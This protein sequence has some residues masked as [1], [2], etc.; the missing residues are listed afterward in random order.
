MH[1]WTVT[2][3]RRKYGSGKVVYW[4]NY[5]G[6]DDLRKREPTTA[7]TLKEAQ[8]FAAKKS[9]ELNKARILGEHPVESVRPVFFEA[10]VGTMNKPGE[11]LMFC[12][13]NHTR[14]T[15]RSGV[16]ASKDVMPFEARRA[17]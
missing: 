10:F 17:P 9:T 1:G 16:S 3:Y 8:V 7:R 12:K 13:S 2:V 11:H 4:L 6:L 5:I 14:K 15:Y